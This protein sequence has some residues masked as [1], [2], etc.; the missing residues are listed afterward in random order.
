[1]VSAFNHL[2]DWNIKQVKTKIVVV[3][4]SQIVEASKNSFEAVTV[5]DK[6]NVIKINLIC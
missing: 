2:D 6:L 4:S 3:I 5:V 1:M